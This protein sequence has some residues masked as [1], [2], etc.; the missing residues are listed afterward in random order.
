MMSSHAIQSETTQPAH[1]IEAVQK[2][3]EPLR[4][5][6]LNHRVYSK[7]TSLESIQIFMRSHIF[8]VWDFMSLLKALQRNLTCVSSPWVPVSNSVAARLINE[9]VLGE[10]SDLCEDGEY[11]SHYELY[12]QAMRTAGADTGQIDRLLETLRANK[13]WQEALVSAE[14]SP[15]I[16]QFVSTTLELTDENDLIALTAAFTFGRENLIPDIFGKIVADL[17]Q[18]HPDELGAFS[19]YLHRHI[20]VDGGEHGPM[21]YQLVENLCGDTIEHWE[22]VARVSQQ[23]IQSRIELWDAIAL[24]LEASESA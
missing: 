3:L 8:A 11:R 2:Q 13:N 19:E 5:I 15:G 9:I 1:G 20:E 18:A 7:L 22:T 21:S 17:T 23:A 12:R 16:S 6:L 14:V 4:K 24:E 10:E